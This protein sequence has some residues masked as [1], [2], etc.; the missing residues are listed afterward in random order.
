MSEA[1]SEDRENS[2]QIKTIAVAGASGHAGKEIAKSLK[3]NGHS[4]IGLVRNASGRS[5]LLEYCDELRE[6]QVTERD[7]LRGKLEN[8]DALISAVG[9][10]YQKDRIPRELV[11]VTANKFLIDEA[12]E[13]NI[14]RF[15]FISACGADPES[16]ISMCK[17][18]GVVEK[19]LIESRLP[20]VIIRPTG[21]YTDMWNFFQAASSIHWLI[22]QGD[23]KMNPI[24]PADLGR[25]VANVFTK[26]ESVNQTLMIGGPE[27]YSFRSFAEVF[28]EVRG[29]K[30]KV[31]SLPEGL[32]NVLIGLIKP[33]NQN[34]WEIA[35]FVTG[36]MTG[37]AD[38]AAPVTGQDSL[39]H[40]LKERYE[41]EK[42]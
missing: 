38:I 39:M 12:V 5:D 18:K 2:I 33:F 35:Q 34:A 23:T 26:P 9:K 29:K 8:I 41:K 14:K 42:K 10:T 6:V 7:S 37:K 4:I 20:Y 16:I 15:G 28:S 19:Y 40:Y 36:M 31:K 11:D 17:M 25:Y 30:I 3:K 21:Y 1:R 27:M 13:A 24:S 32:V 22:G